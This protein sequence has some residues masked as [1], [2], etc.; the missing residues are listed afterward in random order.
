MVGGARK[1]YCSKLRLPRLL[2]PSRT[3]MMEMT[4]ATIGLRMKKLAMELSLGPLGLGGGRGGS[5]RGGGLLDLHHLGL[6]RD[7]GPYLL[8]A[9]DHHLLAGLQARVDDPEVA[10]ALP[11][12]DHAQVDLVVAAHHGHVVDALQLGH[13]AL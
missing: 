6:H 9:L 10:D 1:G 12:L 4:M 8:Q 13:G 7:P 5:G 11:G 2:T 3:M